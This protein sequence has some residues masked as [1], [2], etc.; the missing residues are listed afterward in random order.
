MTHA[1][2]SAVKKSN[3]YTVDHIT[4]HSREIKRMRSVRELVPVCLYP[5]KCSTGAKK[6]SE[7]NF[8]NP[9]SC[10]ASIF[11]RLQ[12]SKRSTAEHV[13]PKITFSCSASLGDTAL[14]AVAPNSNLCHLQPAFYFIEIQN[15]LL[16]F[17]TACCRTVGVLLW[18]SE[19]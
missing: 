1:S 4:L 15:S 9:S 3:K 19:N 5:Y 2:L 8:H 12:S 16:F 17:S 7:D 6:K 14:A 10:Q 18:H 13:D 11:P